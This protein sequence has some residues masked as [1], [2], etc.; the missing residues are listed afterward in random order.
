MQIYFYSA[1]IVHNTHL[2]QFTAD[3]LFSSNYCFWRL[4]TAVMPAILLEIGIPESPTLVLQVFAKGEL[5]SDQR[6][7]CSEGGWVLVRQVSS[8]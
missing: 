3:I 6:R 4:F 2:Q 8:I 1:L 7:P 5:V